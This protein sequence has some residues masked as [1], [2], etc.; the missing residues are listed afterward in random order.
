MSYYLIG[1]AMDEKTDQY[2]QAAVSGEDVVKG[3]SIKWVC[4]H[5]VHC[6]AM[7]ANP[8]Q[9]GFELLWRVTVVKAGPQPKSLAKS[10]ISNSNNIKFRKRSGKKRRIILRIRLAEETAGKIALHK[11]QEKKE[12]AEKDKR[13]RKN[14]DRKIKRR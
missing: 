5:A 11:S 10:R 8:A 12:E 6:N 13:N 9:K 2:K 14:R 1:D 3:L 4:E 7:V